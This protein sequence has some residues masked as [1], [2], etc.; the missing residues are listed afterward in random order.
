MQGIYNSIPET[1]HVSTVYSVAAV[2]YLQSVIHVMLFLVMSCTFTLTLLTVCVC[3]AQYM[4]VFCSSLISSFPRYVAQVLS[5][6]FWNCSS[7]PSCYWYHFCFHIPHAP[8]LYYWV[9]LVYCNLLSFFL[10][11]I[12]VFRNC[13]IYWHAW[14]MFVVIIIIIISICVFFYVR[15]DIICFTKT[16]LTRDLV[17]IYVCI[18]VCLRVCIY[19]FVYVCMYMCVYVCMRVRMYVALSTV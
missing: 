3:S 9:F 15:Q 19:V 8:N 2:L 16:E 11:H 4:A 7:R 14:C 18:Y 1:N 6:W 10:D 5:E 17:F 13:N 12:F